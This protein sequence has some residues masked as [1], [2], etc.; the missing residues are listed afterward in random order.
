MIALVAVLV[1]ATP[2]AGPCV[3]ENEAALAR[4]GGAVREVARFRAPDPV[5][6]SLAPEMCEEPGR[7]VPDGDVPTP[8]DL[9][10]DAYCAELV[11]SRVAPNGLI[12]MF[13]SARLNAGTPEY[14]N[15]RRFARLWTEKHPEYPIATGGGPG[16]MEAGNRGAKEAGGVSV[17]FSTYFGEHGVERPNDYTTHGYMFADFG[18]RE[19]A[20]VKYSPGTVVYAGGFGTAWELFQVLSEMQTGKIRKGPIVLVG[21]TFWEPMV[22]AVK[23]MRDRGTISPNDTGMFVIVDSPEETVSALERGLAAAEG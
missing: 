17:G 1:L 12:T 2:N 23:G 10:L 18:V 16:I 8:A 7:H 5:V 9:A 3:A 21:R 11:V 6:I 20:L 14:E 22:E 13:G 15:A 4:L 19:R